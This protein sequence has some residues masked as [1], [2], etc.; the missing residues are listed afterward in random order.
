M[1][2]YQAVMPLPIRNK[3]LIKYVYNP[4]WI[5]QLG[6]FSI[7][8]NNDDNLFI[9]KAFDTYKFI[10]ARLNISN[11][12]DL[13]QKEKTEKQTHFLLLN[14]YEKLKQNFRSDRK[15][16]LKR[17]V[18]YGLIGKWNADLNPFLKLFFKNITTSITSITKEDFNKLQLILET[19]ILKGKG[20]LLSIYDSNNNLV[21]SG[22]LLKHNNRITILVSTTNFKNRKNGANTYLINQAIE[23]YKNT[24]KIFD[25][26]GSSIKSIANYF[27][28]FGATQETYYQ[29]NYNNLPLLYKIIKS[30]KK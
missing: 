19:C 15:K 14:D 4:L 30:L 16:D 21:A 10:D 12:I 13:F 11:K 3:Y 23:K 2:D 9:K 26:G 25:F 20:E 29:I 1:N 24:Y 28:S 8:K 18:K 6:V 7:D 17:A 22:F 5:L 27:L